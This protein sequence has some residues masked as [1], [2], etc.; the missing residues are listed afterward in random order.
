MFNFLYFFFALINLI[1]SL[2]IIFLTLNS[3]AC[4]IISETF[5]LVDNNL[6]S[7]F[8]FSFLIIFIKFLPIDPVEPNITIFFFF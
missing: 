2:I 5:L 8:F 1:L 3:F 7:K 6:I 4:L